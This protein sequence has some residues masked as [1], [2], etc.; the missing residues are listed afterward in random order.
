LYAREEA[1]RERREER[2]RDDD[3]EVLERGHEA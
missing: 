1:Q 2:D 3:D